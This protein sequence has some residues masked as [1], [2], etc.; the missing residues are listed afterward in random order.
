MEETAMGFTLRIEK[1][2]RLWERILTLKS[3]LRYI[4]NAVLRYTDLVLKECP[5]CNPPGNDC[6]SCFAAKSLKKAIE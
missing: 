2:E 1:E 4:K 5:L 6:T 3:E